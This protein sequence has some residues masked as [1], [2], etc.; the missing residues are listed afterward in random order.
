M[1]LVRQPLYSAT[2]SATTAGG[3]VLSFACRSSAAVQVGQVTCEMP[4]GAGAACAVRLNGTLICPLVATG[5]AAAGEP[6]VPMVP[7]D[8]LT[9]EWTG[10]PAGASGKIGVIYDLVVP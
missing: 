8:L 7:G 1:A 3:L 4:T 10:A 5:D 9:V 6:F 2:G